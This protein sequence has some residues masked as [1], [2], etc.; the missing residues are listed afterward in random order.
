MK[1]GVKF[2]GIP[3]VFLHHYKD[4]LSRWMRD[5]QKIGPFFDVWLRVDV[6]GPLVIG[7]GSSP[8]MVPSIKRVTLRGSIVG[9]TLIVRP[10]DVK[11]EKIIAKHSEELEDLYEPRKEFRLL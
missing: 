3:G 6:H 5:V 9:A 4:E 7:D 1:P 2:L 10:K 11:T 8:P